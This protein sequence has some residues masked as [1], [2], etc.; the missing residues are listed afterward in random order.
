MT[1]SFSAGKLGLE[2]AAQDQAVSDMEQVITFYC[3]SRNVRYS[4]DCGW[5]ELLLPM[6][7][8]GFSRA[9]LFNCFYAMLIKYIPRCEDYLLVT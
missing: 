6:V 2:R 9:D 8:L 5:P 4:S 1:L 3:K 7:A